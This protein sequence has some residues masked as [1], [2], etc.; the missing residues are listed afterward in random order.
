MSGTADG[1][2]TGVIGGFEMMEDLSKMTLLGGGKSI[3]N[4][5]VGTY[6]YLMQTRNGASSG[7]SKA[8]NGSDQWNNAVREFFAAD[9]D[10]SVFDE[11]WRSPVKLHATQLF[12]PP[13][14]SKIAPEM[15]GD[16]RLVEAAYWLCHYKG[17]IAYPEGGTFRFWGWA[18]NIMFV[19]IN[20]EIVLEASYQRNLN[21]HLSDW[22]ASANENKKYPS[23]GTTSGQPWRVGD[24]FTMEPGEPVDMEILFGEQPGGGFTS[25][26][27]V[28]QEGV[29]YPER[30]R[31]SGPL[32]PIFKTAEVPQ[33]ILDEMY[34]YTPPGVV[35]FTNGP[36]FSVY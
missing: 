1:L 27:L 35:D 26:L 34:Y 17:K 10:P 28:Q 12:V 24:W 20:G 11:F 19:R 4:D 22:R 16:D 25:M 30:D 36:I 6:Y 18:D 15:F 7:I 9:W 8:T 21:D 31:L 3:G 2:G 33:H 32:L 5:L 13:V 23:I 29:E 14:P